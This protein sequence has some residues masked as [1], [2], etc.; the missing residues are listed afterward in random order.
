MNTDNTS[1]T[2]KTETQCFN[3]ENRVRL[4]C[5]WKASD[6]LLFIVS[7][8]PA[9]LGCLFGTVLIWVVQGIWWPTVAYISFFPII[10]GVAETRFL[11]SHCPY[12]A[13]EGR[14]L[15]CLANH[16]LLK[17]WRYHPEP[18][19]RLEKVLMLIL[20]IF[21][22]IPMPGLIWGYDIW[23]FSE[24]FSQYGQTTWIAVIGLAVITMFSLLAFAFVM[25]KHICALCINFSCP[26]NRVNKPLR[27]AYL[28]R[29]PVMRKAWEETGYRLGQITDEKQPSCGAVATGVDLS[30]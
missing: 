19:N 6:L 15:H 24:N 14:V 13:Q 28:E 22:L 30:V 29:N 27:D 4:N 3:C 9:M 21:F 26:F 11:C 2:W 18:M 16:G 23:F 12:Y 17:I 7:V 1:C 8:M 10:L 25:V 5:R 20:A